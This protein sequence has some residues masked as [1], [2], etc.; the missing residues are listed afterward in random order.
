MIKF[1]LLSF[2]VTSSALAL[3][4]KT[5]FNLKGELQAK[6]LD[7]ENSFEVGTFNTDLKI[8]LGEY[9]SFEFN[10]LLRYSH[11]DLYNEN[12]APLFWSNYPNESIS[13][14]MFK[15]KK[16]DEGKYTR[17]ESVLN[18]FFYRWGDSE[19]NFTVGRM[20]VQYGEGLS[21]NP[22]N[23]FS[24]PTTFS[25]LQN[26]RQGNDGLKFSFNMERELTL[27]LFIFGN[28]N[29]DPEDEEVTRTIFLN[30]D[31]TYDPKNHFHYIIGE[32]QKRHI[33]GMEYK[34]SFEDGLFF[35]QAAIESERL[36][37]KSSSESMQHGLIG[38]EKDLG[39]FWVT[40][41]EA[42]RQDFDKKE[43]Y[44][45]RAINFLPQEYFFALINQVSLDEKLLLNFNFSQDIKT[46][47]QYLLVKLDYT[48]SNHLKTHA[49]YGKT[50]S[51]NQEDEENLFQD[52]IPMELGVGMSF[53]F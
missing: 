4:T 41:L 44:G 20:F 43:N 39:D 22:I 29:L 1:L 48:F 28:K 27:N 9:R 23:P 45:W 11:S 34:Y 19:T 52:Q 18:K 3:E 33:L 25:T 16:I 26:I 37:K 35:I 14:N 32:D 5:D 17:T 51:F 8:E 47:F 21:F 15:L 53:I 31:Y 2:L 30:A 10:W 50:L 40:R 7:N 6:N 12:E 24:Y 49:F 36:N 46:D 13:R 42:G 38:I